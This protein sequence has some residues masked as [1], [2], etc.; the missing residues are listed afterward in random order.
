MTDPTVP[1]PIDPSDLTPTQATQKLPVGLPEP[2]PDATL[3]LTPPPI[4]E[5]TE[6]STPPALPPQVPAP[7]ATLRLDASQRP[8]PPS[9][10]PIEL[11]IPAPPPPPIH[12]APKP[13]RRHLGRWVALTAVALALV[14]GGALLWLRPDLVGLRATPP[15]PNTDPSSTSEA[16]L[17]PT[18]PPQAPPVRTDVPPALR[19]YHERALKGDA[20]AMAILGTM[21][22]NG[23]NVPADRAE[24]LKWLRRAADLGNAAAQ[25]Q[26]QQ[27]EAR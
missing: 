23:L 4:P 24:G 17:R 15:T 16:P 21:Y 27:L 10:P 1:P 18:L 20:N 2:P 25:K 5:T 9:P 3:R 6:P 26:L 22:Y 8:G 19:S 11:A 12:P 13:P 7:D 14:G